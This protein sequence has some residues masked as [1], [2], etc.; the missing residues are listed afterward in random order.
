M[1]STQWL[2]ARR[3]F[4]SESVESSGELQ[5]A[6]ERS[7]RD[8]AE[9]YGASQIQILEGLEAVRKRPG[10]YIG[11]TSTA[12]LH[13][14]V[15]ELVDNSIDEFLAGHGDTIEIQLHLDGSVTVS[16]N[17]RGIPTD[18]HSEGRTALEVVMTVLH[19]GGKFNNSVYKGFGW[20]PWCRRLCC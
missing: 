8:M 19:A 4:C 14:L 9:S 2:P 18:I 17:A 12:G 20:T 13:H 3:R 5:S 11:D 10:M 6:S 1:K 16:D 7:G 15:Y